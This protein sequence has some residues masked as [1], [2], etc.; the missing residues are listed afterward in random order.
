MS[1]FKLLI[2]QEL[3]R[4]MRGKLLWSGAILVAL[5]VYDLFVQPVFGN[6]WYAV[7]AAAAAAGL[8][9]L[10]YGLLV[11][12][13]AL[14][15]RPDSLILRGPLR[16]VK[17]SYGRID[18][19]TTTKMAKHFPR[20]ELKGQEWAM[21]EP[22]HHLTCIFVEMNSFP[23]AFTR[24]RLWFPRILFSPVRPGLLI[25]VEDWM[26]LSRAIDKARNEWHEKRRGEQ[27]GDKRSPAAQ[28][29]DY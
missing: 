6:A 3:S 17:I 5:G 22:F 16:K 13:T 20:E 24:R 1:K 4:R 28:I 10:Y 23:R 7:W 14:Y 9:W 15:V 2:Y 8:L 27:Q 11:R 19:A 21:V 25:V 26:N 18:T 29:L 12:R